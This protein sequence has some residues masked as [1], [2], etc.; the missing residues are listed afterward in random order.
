MTSISKDPQFYKFSLYGFLKNLN[1]SDPF[2]ILFFVQEG[3]SYAS[4]GLL[5]SVK[6]IL[7]N[8]LEIPSGIFADGYGKRRAM[9]LCFL[10]YIGSFIVFFFFHGFPFFLLAMAFFA[11]GEAFRTGTHKSL[12]LEYLRQT[13]QLHLKLEYY[14]KTRSFSQ[15]GM[16]VS[17]GA[18]AVMVFVSGNYRLLFIISVIPYVLGLLL[19]ISYPASLD[20]LVPAK[21]SLSGNDAGNQRRSWAHYR[22]SLEGLAV[23]FKKPVSRKALLNSGVYG[24]AYKSI[25]DYIQ[26]VLVRVV[27]LSSILKG[28]EIEKRSS[29]LIGLTYIVIYLLTS[30]AAGRSNRI[31]AKFRTEESAI[32]TLFFSSAA[33]IL[34]SGLCLLINIPAGAAGAL[35]LLYILYNLRRPLQ[36]SYISGLIPD[37]AMASGLSGESQ[38]QSIIN[39]VSAPLIGL[40][41]DAFGLPAAL[42][43]SGAGMLFLGSILHLSEAAE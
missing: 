26:P 9:I 7:V 32:N 4:I 27:L 6:A 14:G 1:F 43:I 29:L 15:I 12:I 5:F 35:I 25:K 10:A 16:A 36:L 40:T 20:Q 13:G 30:A 31:A 37:E 18:A 11:F 42:L 34:I 41:I 3:L 21:D 23:M 38:L 28:M 22:A 24:G 17:A 8:V 33:V 39:A 2:I 19:I